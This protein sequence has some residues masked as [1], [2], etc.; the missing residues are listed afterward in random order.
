MSIY[1]NKEDRTRLFTD[2]GRQFIINETGFN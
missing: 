1:I 2:T